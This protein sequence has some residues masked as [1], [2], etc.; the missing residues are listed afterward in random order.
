MGGLGGRWRFRGAWRRCGFV[1]QNRLG[2][3][4]HFDAL[5]LEAFQDSFSQLALHR[6]LVTTLAEGLDRRAEQVRAVMDPVWQH[7][8]FATF[9]TFDPRWYNALPPIGAKARPPVLEMASSG[10]T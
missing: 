5:G 3:K 9:Y 10:R 8:D 4:G 1:Q 2:G 6:I 7:K